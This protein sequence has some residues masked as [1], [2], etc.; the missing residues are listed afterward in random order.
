MQRTVLLQNLNWLKFFT[1]T[2]TKD[3]CGSKTSETSIWSCRF[4]L[5]FQPEEEQL[6]DMHGVPF[7]HLLYVDN[8]FSWQHRSHYPIY[9]AY[10]WCHAIDA[11]YLVLYACIICR[12]MIDHWYICQLQNVNYHYFTESLLNINEE[13]RRDRW[14]PCP[15]AAHVWWY[16]DPE[17]GKRLTQGYECD[18]ARAIQWLDYS[19]IAGGMYRESGTVEGQDSERSTGFI[20]QRQQAPGSMFYWRIAGWSTAWQQV[21]IVHI[22]HIMYWFQVWNFYIFCIE[23]HIMY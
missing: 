9:S 4:N 6:V 21:H 11:K 19:T 14:I 22:L 10:W 17:K 20:W 23:L 1:F 3:S 16:Y 13:A 5:V 7:I 18:S 2:T 15:P 12:Y 8:L